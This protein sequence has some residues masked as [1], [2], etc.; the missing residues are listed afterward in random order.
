MKPASIPQLLLTF[1]TLCAT[2]YF[3]SAQN[4]P[5]IGSPSPE[6][7]LSPVRSYFAD[8]VSSSMLKG[9]P[10]I[11]VLIS[12]GC[13]AS[14]TS[15]SEI[16]ELNR[17]F[18]RESAFLLVGR[19]DSKT[20]LLFEKFKEKLDLELPIAYNDDLFVQFKAKRVSGL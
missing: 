17:K 12:S 4:L 10:Y 18:K 16:N 8:T 6:F 2:A 13:A 14:F 5:V 11:L 15:L 9:K 7:L 3:A 1:F 19:S 20:Q